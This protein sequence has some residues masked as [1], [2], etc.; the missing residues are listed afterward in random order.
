MLELPGFTAARILDVEE[1]AEGGLPQ[2][3]VHYH[4]TDRAAFDEYNRLHAERMSSGAAEHFGDSIRVQRRLLNPVGATEQPPT[5]TRCLNCGAVL[6]GQYCGVCGQRAGSR[7]IS[8]W[9]LFRDGLGDL[10]DIDS[11]LWRTLGALLTRPGLLTAEY[12]QGRRARYMPPFRMYLAFSLLFFLVAFFSADELSIVVDGQPDSQT[13]EAAET[14][15]QEDG[16]SP[17]DDSVTTPL[18]PAEGEQPS[19]SSLC[20]DI[21]I[22]LGPWLGERLT[23]E[24]VREACQRIVADRGR[25]LVRA[26]IDDLPTAMFLFL[27]VLAL[28]LNLLYPFSRRY[29]V[30]HL[31]FIVHYQ[32]FVFLV[33]TLQV[34]FARLL[35]WVGT[36]SGLAALTSLFV[37]FYIPIYLHR[38]MRRVYR[39]GFM[40]TF[41]K[42]N[43]L[44]IAYFIA[45][46]LMTF[47]TLIIAALRI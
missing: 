37:A 38:S 46:V 14:V 1:T 27:P 34:L 43:V 5:S 16:E 2:R 19:G 9:E 15:L 25:N 47:V 32:S 33:L 13:G 39:Q 45:L 35:E 21:E 23:E 41:L 26:L 12:L 20:K 3:T 40:A 29:Y 22:D 6:R 36:L 7:L 8:L 30:E 17:T 10:L 44:S 31:L 24:R 4:L 28:V 42:F 11:R 18:H